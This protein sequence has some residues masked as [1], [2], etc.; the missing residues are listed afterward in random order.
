[1]LVTD[2]ADRQPYAELVHDSL[3]TSWG[4]LRDLVASNA[5]FLPP[6]D[7]KRRAH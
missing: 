2:P 3:I 1:M 6:A 4:R 5:D 7:R